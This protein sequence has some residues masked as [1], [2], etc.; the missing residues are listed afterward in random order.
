MPKAI[1]NAEKTFGWDRLCLAPSFGCCAGTN[2]F[3]IL[4][5]KKATLP[6]VDGAAV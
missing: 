2:A 3:P 4:E 5:E 1:G 6:F